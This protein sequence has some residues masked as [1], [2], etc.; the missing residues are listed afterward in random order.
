MFTIKLVHR[1]GDAEVMACDSYA[2]APQNG[3]TG[4]TITLIRRGGEKEKVQLVLGDIAYIENQSGKTI[5]VVRINAK[6]SP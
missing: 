4:P 1:G 2:K 3:G 6:P 5:D